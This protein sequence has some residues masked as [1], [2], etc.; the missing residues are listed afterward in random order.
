[1]SWILRTIAISSRYIV[2]A[3]KSGSMELLEHH[4]MDCNIY[5]RRLSNNGSRRLQGL[6]ILRMRLPRNAS[7]KEK[8]IIFY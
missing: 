1:M 2:F 6:S 4:S 8:V 7:K 5:S 3:T